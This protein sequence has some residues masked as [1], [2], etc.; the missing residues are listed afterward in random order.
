MQPT[1]PPSKKSSKPSCRLPLWGNPFHKKAVHRIR[2]QLFSHNNSPNH[3]EMND[4]CVLVGRHGRTH[5]GVSIPNTRIVCRD[6]NNG[7]ALA[8]RHGRAHRHRPYP[9]HHI[10]PHN[11]HKQNNHL[12]ATHPNGANRPTRNPPKRNQPPTRN[13]SNDINRPTRNLPKRNQPFHAQSTQ[14]KS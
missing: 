10:F 1:K 6:F 5:S 4:G 7:C 13:P 2:A 8:G 11:P 12:C 3:G 9:L 14:T